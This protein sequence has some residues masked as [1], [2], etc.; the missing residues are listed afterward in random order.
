MNWK[1]V[2]LALSAVISVSACVS[3]VDNGVSSAAVS[4]DSGSCGPNATYS[5]DSK[6]GVLTICGIG[7]MDDYDV[8]EKNQP[9]WAY[10]S[11]VKTVIVGNSVTSIGER[12]FYGCPLDVVTIPDSVTSFGKDAFNCPFLGSISVGEGNTTFSSIGGVLFSKDAGNLI[13]YPAGASESYSIPDSVTSIGDYAFYEGA[14]V[15]V[16]IPDSVTSIGD[17]AFYGCYSL[18]SMTIPDSVSSVG[19]YAFSR[20][21]GIKNLYV[22]SNPLLRLERSVF[23][24]FTFYDKDGST[25]IPVT[26]RIW[27]DTVSSEPPTGW[28]V[29]QNTP[30]QGR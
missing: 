17:R 29:L 4:D 27:E 10:R 1:Y 20:C 16:T 12:A 6:T 28:Y 25:V 14:A 24:G 8:D 2:F 21:T 11:D 30:Y 26:Q 18:A 7:D 9:W 13:Q 3:Y 15:S 23:G 5:F 22:S 19:E